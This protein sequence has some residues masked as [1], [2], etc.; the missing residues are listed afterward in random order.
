MSE[1]KGRRLPQ[2]KMTVYQ[3]SDWWWNQSVSMALKT[4]LEFQGKQGGVRWAIKMEKGFKRKKVSKW[5]FLNIIF[6]WFLKWVPVV[7]A[8]IV[9]ITSDGKRQRY[10]S[11]F[12][13]KNSDFT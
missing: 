12:A 7:N 2:Y 13:W 4:Y 3:K 8:E 10:T 1:Y 11:N 6:K 9:K 5:N